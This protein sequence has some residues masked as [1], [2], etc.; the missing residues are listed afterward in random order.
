M[1]APA[2]LREALIAFISERHT[3]PAWAAAIQADALMNA[4]DVRLKQRGGGSAA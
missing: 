3:L 1:S 2:N 4:F